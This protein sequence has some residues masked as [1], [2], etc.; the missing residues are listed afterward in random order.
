MMMQIISITFVLFCIIV[1][2]HQSPQFSSVVAGI[3]LV[4]GVVPNWGA[5][6]TGPCWDTFSKASGLCSPPPS[7]YVQLV[8]GGN[9]AQVCGLP[10]TGIVECWN[11]DSPYKIRGSPFSRIFA[12][13]VSQPIFNMFA[14]IR[15]NDSFAEIYAASQLAYVSQTKANDLS[16]GFRHLCILDYNNILNCFG[17]GDP[18]PFPGSRTPRDECLPPAQ[19]KFLEIA[20]GNGNTCGI[21]AD[22]SRAVV[23]WG[24]NDWDKSN[25]PAN[26]SFLHVYTGP[27][28]SCGILTDSSALCWGSNLYGERNPPPRKWLQLSLGDKFSV[29]LTTDNEYVCWGLQAYCIFPGK[30]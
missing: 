11:G 14:G 4:C 17:C 20:A 15:T 12:G 29:G 9:R 30:Q 6:C 10:S 5:L 23:C 26:S 7:I 18:Y 16:I 19:T 3:N 1:T 22:G 13:G 28:H 8:T 25:A 2:T 21:V 24:Y 27:T